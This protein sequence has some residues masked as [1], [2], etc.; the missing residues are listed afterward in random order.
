MK[1]WSKDRRSK[2]EEIGYILIIWFNLKIW[3]QKKLKS[4]KFEKDND[5]AKYL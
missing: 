4:L 3:W 5:N 2:R 1:Q